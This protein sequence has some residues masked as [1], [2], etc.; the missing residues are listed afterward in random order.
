M[1]EQM[2][3]WMRQMLIDKGV[4]TEQGLSRKARI[5]THRP[6]GLPTLAGI[7]SDLAGL[8]AWC[9]LGELHAYGEAMALISGRR[10]YELWGGRLGHRDQWQ[11][12]GRPAGSSRHPVFSEHRCHDPI[13]PDWITPSKPAPIRTARNLEEIP[14]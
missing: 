4:L 3:A 13:P 1:A 6:C 10:T 7:D 9:D 2:A 8:D 5:R 12:Q 14:W 11:I